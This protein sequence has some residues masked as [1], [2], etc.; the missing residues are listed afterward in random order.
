[1]IVRTLQQLLGTERDVRGPVWAS[2][3]FLLAEDGVGFTVTET[4]VEAGSEQVLWYKYHVEA[5][6]VVEG[7]GEVENLG[8]GEVFALAPGSIYVLDGNEKHRLKADTRMKLVCIFTP[9]LSGRETHDE[10]GAYAPP[11]D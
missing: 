11:A 6:Y 4:T 10:D 3:R 2:R 5:N 8:T 9:A 7:E 1:M